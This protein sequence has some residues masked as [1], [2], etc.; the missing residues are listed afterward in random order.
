MFSNILQSRWFS[1]G[2]Q[3]W[4]CSY[5]HSLNNVS[6]GQVFGG[7]VIPG[8]THLPI[9]FS[10]RTTANLPT[11]SSASSGFCSYSL[12]S[13]SFHLPGHNESIL[14]C[15]NTHWKGYKKFFQLK[16]NSILAALVTDI[17]LN[18]RVVWKYWHRYASYEM[19]GQFSLCACPVLG[20][21]STWKSSREGKLLWCGHI[22]MGKKSSCSTH[23][24]CKRV[25][26]QHWFSCTSETGRFTPAVCLSTSPSVLQ[27]IAKFFHFSIFSLLPINGRIQALQLATIPA[28]SFLFGQMHLPAHIPTGQKYFIFS[29]FH[30]IG[31]HV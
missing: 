22:S 7:P 16:I 15:S 6:C 19:R 21:S 28:S 5:C 29:H 12:F 30:T 2:L 26:K 10:K 23:F 1:S 13:V 27:T 3:N 24:G 20:P 31:Y 9:A 25:F 11:S 18:P 8:V 17:L 4:S 14:P